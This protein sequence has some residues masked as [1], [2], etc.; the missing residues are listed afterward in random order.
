MPDDD[1]DTL[2][3]VTDEAPESTEPAWQ[4]A[5]DLGPEAARDAWAAAAKTVLEETAGSYQ[6]VLTHKELAAAVQQRSLVRTRQQPHYW[7]EDVLGRVTAACANQSE[8]LVSAL[9]V[10][11]EG[12]VG[13]KYGIAVTAATG[14]T[15]DDYDSHAADQR[16]ACYRRFDA[17]GLPADGGFAELTPRQAGI[18]DRARKQRIAER[19][20][21][22][23]PKC[24]MQL[25]ATMRCNYCDE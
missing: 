13:E 4:E 10:N 5:A 20:A 24:H 18:R 11:A 25:P 15:L 8:P 17:V 16:L 2:A 22:Q 14:D 19:V 12:S 21:P 9:A 23:C 3:P 6:S 7:I 1:L